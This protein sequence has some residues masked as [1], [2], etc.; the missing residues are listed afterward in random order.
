MTVEEALRM[1][2]DAF[3][4][5]GIDTPRL[6]AEVLLSHILY[7]GR[8]TL[9]ARDERV[10]T[11]SEEEK[12]IEFRERRRKREPVAYIIG[13]KEFYSLNFF[14]DSRVLV[15]RPET[16]LLVDLV[17]EHTPPNGHVL[18]VGTGSGAIAVSVKHHRP[19]V[20]VWASD[21][22]A[23]ALEVARKNAE[24]LIGAGEIEFLHGDLF[25]PCR[26]AR[27]DIIVS[28]PPYIGHE[29]RASLPGELFHEP[30]IALFCDNNGMGIIH[31]LIDE[32]TKHL[33]ENG[34]VLIEIGAEMSEDVVA[35]AQSCEFTASV[36]NDYS[37]LPRAV[38]L[39]K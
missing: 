14:V 35:W 9:I 13:E 23:D 12:L 11:Q 29:E 27:F 37:G 2:H 6:D 25:T 26:Y 15:P 24:T 30:E 34:K 8:H 7:C 10:L 1:L 3:F 36:F 18:D 22:S 4:A 16:E 39:Q 5:C 20:R 21:I 17:I 38:L 31:R 28:N 19:D 32:A 33:R